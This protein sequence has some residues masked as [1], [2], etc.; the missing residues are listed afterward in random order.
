VCL[1]NR[2]NG[3]SLNGT[4][5]LPPPLGTIRFS[6]GEKPRSDRR[7]AGRPRLASRHPYQIGCGR[8]QISLARSIEQLRPRHTGPFFLTPGPFSRVTVSYFHTCRQ[9]ALGKSRIARGPG[10][11][12]RST[13][14]G[15][16]PCR[17]SG[18]TRSAGRLPRALSPF[19]ESVFVRQ[20]TTAGGLAWLVISDRPLPVPRSRPDSPGAS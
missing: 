17:R 1:R 15:P 19:S 13:P 16:R 7:S 10:S 14:E 8:G 3:L 12:L 6:G 4:R 20:H 9:S 2:P 5:R 11:P 18:G